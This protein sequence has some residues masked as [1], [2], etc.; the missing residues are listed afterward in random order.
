MVYRLA[1]GGADMVRLFGSKGA[2]ASEMVGIGLPVPPGFVITTDA[3]LEY[4]RQG[5]RFPDGLW[6]AVVENVHVLE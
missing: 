3:A 4:Y 2:H 6:D 1:E 5:R